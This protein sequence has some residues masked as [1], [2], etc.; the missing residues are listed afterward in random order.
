MI[1]PSPYS[2]ISSSTSSK[3]LWDLS[4]AL[5]RFPSQSTQT[6]SIYAAIC[7][8]RNGHYFLVVVHL[9]LKDYD[10]LRLGRAD[11]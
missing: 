3:S 4:H 2:A 7:P 9:N 1:L 11:V 8:G 10:L 5:L 6:L